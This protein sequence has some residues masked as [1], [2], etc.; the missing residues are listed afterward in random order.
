V[1]AWADDEITITAVQDTLALGSAFLFVF[2]DD[3]ANAS[4]FPVTLTAVGGGETIELAATD[5]PDTAAASATV[6]WLLHLGATEPDDA[7]A[8]SLQAEVLVEL[9]ATDS[10]DTVAGTA[11]VEWR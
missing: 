8:G 5:P 2:D 10:P 6:E 9:A 3:V 1:T 11:V 4:G 7:L